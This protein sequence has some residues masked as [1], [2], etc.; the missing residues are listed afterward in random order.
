MDDISDDE[1]MFPQARMH[2]PTMLPSPPSPPT[3]S[4]T[5]QLIV[6]SLENDPSDKVL[7]PPQA[8]E[9]ILSA[10]ANTDLPQPLT[11]RILNPKTTRS[12]HVG[13]R[14]FSAPFQTIGIPSWILETLDLR[15]DDIASVSIRV[16]PKAT[17]VKLRP[18]EAGYI[19]DDW[20]ALLESQLRTH[21]TLTRGETL[22]VAGGPGVVFRFLIDEVEPAE[23]VNLIDTD[24]SV[25]IEEMSEDNARQTQDQRI[26]AATKRNVEITD[27]VV[28]HSVSGHVVQGEYVYYRLKEWDRERNVEITVQ[29]QGDADLVL[30]TSEDWKP[31]VDMHVWSDMSVEPTKRVTLSASNVELSSAR[32]IQIGVYGYTD[33]TFEFQV[34][35]PVG[36]NVDLKP[37]ANA[38]GFTECQNCLSWVP[39]R[40]LMLHQNFCLRNNYRCP[41]CNTVLP[42]KEK[43][44]HWHCEDCTAHGISESSFTKHRIT[45]HSARQC[46][47][48]STFQSLSSLAFH[49]STLCPRKVIKCRFCQTFKEQG[50]L[51]T[52]S[53]NDMLA[54][55]TPHEADCGSRTLECP[56]CNRRLRLKDF[57]IH[58]RIHDTE[59][60]A[61]PEPQ[62]CRNLNC[63]RPRSDNPLGLCTICFGPL[64][65]PL[66]DPLHTKLRSRLERKLL[67]QLLS[68]CGQEHCSN[69][70]YCATA[71]G[72]AIGMAEAMK[73]IRPQVQGMLA[74]DAKFYICVDQTV[75]S[76]AFLAGMV[77]AEGVY[78][79]EWCRRA[80]EEAK[81][82]LTRART[83]LEQNGRRRDE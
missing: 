67:T 77:A 76:R 50:D 18:L 10:T 45:E 22:A 65:S 35:Q 13:V 49:R 16:L 20:K 30:S 66:Y 31:R 26:K 58:S 6:K 48:G 4:W 24:V 81:G 9:D 53:S 57:E 28:D 80:I 3:L 27:V 60:L 32:V 17:R 11:F 56:I 44:S 82:D 25:D 37:N 23:A 19:E 1:E 68:G 73:V 62:N 75:Q 15:N 79:I 59:R 61:R 51:S 2:L 63:T 34:R 72:R 42:Q 43:S 29:G 36:N 38:P 33:A 41:Q 78:G 46:I 64:Y 14:E 55:L 83:W 39:E 5:Q 7:L 12:T 52:L 8:L 71:K 47:C 69:S 40:S 70:E 74:P 54:G 21:T